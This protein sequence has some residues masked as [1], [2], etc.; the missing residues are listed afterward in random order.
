MV[1]IIGHRGAS[2]DAP[3]NTISS[4]KE[5]FMQGADGIEV[6][7]R[8]TKDGKVVCI[9][10]K[11]TLR[12]TGLSLNVKDAEHKEIKELD[13]GSWKANT[14]KNEPIPLLEEV[15]EEMPLDKEIFIEV[16]TGLEIIDPLDSLIHNSKLKQENISIISFND[17]VIKKVKSSLPDITGNLLVA[18]DPPYN[19]KGLPQLLKKID[20]DGVGVQNH[21]KLT[22][23]FVK[24]IK[25]LN[26]DI[27]VW[28]VDD[29]EDA[30]KYSLLGI[31]SIT[32]NK[33]KYIK[34]YL[35]TPK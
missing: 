32:T 16:K 8:L 33:P 28:T 15:L 17:L 29:G 13:A 10:D 7:V 30:K 18:F 4:I 26:K 14:W 21:S 23:G 2:E 35:S 1:R 34:G 24:K 11:N 22:K 25:N 5:A 19:E 6:D 3:E 9:H 20:A 12:T 27:H 31:S